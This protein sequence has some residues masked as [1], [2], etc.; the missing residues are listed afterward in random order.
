M[1]GTEAVVDIVISS[2]MSKPFF[3]NLPPAHQA[4][5]AEKIAV[6]KQDALN[7]LNELQARRRASGASL[8]ISQEDVADMSR[9]IF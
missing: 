2:L 9:A 3:K 1:L 5:A 4:L 6:K 7:Y 8:V